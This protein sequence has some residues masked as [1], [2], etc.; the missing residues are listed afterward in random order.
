MVAAVGA[1]LALSPAGRGLGE[2]LFQ[3][4]SLVAA[5]HPGPLPAGEREQ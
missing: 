1:V 5:P 4:L 3:T 2:G